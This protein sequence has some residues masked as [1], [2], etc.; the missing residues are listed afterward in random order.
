MKIYKLLVDLYWINWFTPKWGLFNSKWQFIEDWIAKDVNIEVLHKIENL[1]SYTFPKVFSEIKENIN[2]GKIKN[3]Y[4]IWDYVVEEWKGRNTFMK[5]H[6]IKILEK[7]VRYNIVFLSENKYS[8]YKEED[9]RRPT[10]EELL[11]FYR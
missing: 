9:L 10:K 1:P 3:K 2:I 4:K 8:Y 5:I 6:S 11:K 7:E